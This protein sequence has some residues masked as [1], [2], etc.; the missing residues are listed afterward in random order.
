MGI[1]SQ[2]NTNKGIHFGWIISI[3]CGLVML[4]TVGLTFNCMSMYLNPLME[5][6]DISN[7]LRSSLTMFFQVG[8][9]LSLLVVGKVTTIMG[10]RR[11]ILVFSLVM[12]LG[13]L[14][15]SISSQVGICFLA[16]FIIG[17]G[18]GLCGIVPVTFLLTNW[19][20]KKR[21][22]ALGI[23]MSGSGIATLFAPSMI[24]HVI[25]S[26]GVRNAF[27]IQ[28]A[29]IAV[30][31]FVAF[32]IV[33][34]RPEDKNCLPYG[35]DADGSPI[36]D[37]DESTEFSFR[38]AIHNNDFI[39]LSFVLLIL[40]M[41]IS[42]LVQHLAPLISQSGYTEVIAAEAVSVY[43][44][45][46]LFGKPLF[47]TVIDRLGIPKANT[48]VYMLIIM[49]LVDGLLLGRNTFQVFLIPLFLAC[50]SAP[51]A[52]VGLPIWTTTLFGKS[53][54]KSVF[55]ILKLVYTF[56]GVIGASI[57]GIVID[58]TGSYD[59]LFK[60]YIAF[61]LITYFLLQYLFVFKKDSSVDRKENINA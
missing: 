13:Y 17:A 47:G 5:E 34:E 27:L 55:P 60:L 26:L 2:Y 41:L 39:I 42:P 40:G 46:M 33:K 12:A 6:M 56:G 16:M 30:L 43:G 8:S 51:M 19:F 7:T 31:S 53:S 1:D 32:T 11:S 21:G 29:T 58:H 25:S 59:D 3:G 37:K 54:M 23:A 4:Y 35:H 28:A 24:N 18:Y 50:G 57:P 36:L 38:E 22:L 14:I 9:A 20:E 45:C 48:Y 52:T 61:A 10:S 15:L 44:I 49:A